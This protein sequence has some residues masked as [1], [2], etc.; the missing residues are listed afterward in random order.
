MHT[1]FFLIV[2]RGYSWTPRCASTCFKATSV[3]SQHAPQQGGVE[4]LG[5]GQSPLHFTYGHFILW[6]GAEQRQ[7]AWYRA[8]HL[9]YVHGHSSDQPVLTEHQGAHV[10]GW[11]G[12]WKRKVRV[13]FLHN[14]SHSGGT[15]LKSLHHF[16]VPNFAQWDHARSGGGPGLMKRPRAGHLLLFNVARHSHYSVIDCWLAHVLKSH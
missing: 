7:A 2:S 16:S 4:A 6:S 12:D 9:V 13:D 14:I 11:H 15:S 8:E 1:S 10:L 5:R 3:P